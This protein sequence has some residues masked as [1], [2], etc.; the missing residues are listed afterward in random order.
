MK[1]TQ[2]GRLGETRAGLDPD[3]QTDG[4]SLTQIL[5]LRLG[6]ESVSKYENTKPQK[7][8]SKLIFCAAD[9]CSRC[10]GACF[11]V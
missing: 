4:P 11:I 1:T 6:R 8:T 10:E 7:Q 9:T 3:G 2:Y 5:D